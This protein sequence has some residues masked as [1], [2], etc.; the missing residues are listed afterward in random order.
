[1]NPLARGFFGEYV[2]SKSAAAIYITSYQPYIKLR[3]DHRSIIGTAIVVDKD[4]IE[5]TCLLA[6]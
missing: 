3:S 4:L 1:M 2:S 6:S 5:G